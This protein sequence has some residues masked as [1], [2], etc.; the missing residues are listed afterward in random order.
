MIPLGLFAIGLLVRAAVGSAFAGP[1]YPDSYYYVNVAHQIAAGNGLTVDYIWN[2]VEVGGRLP[3]NPMLPIPANAHW[4]P[5]AALVQVPFIW[6]LGPVPL[7]SGVPLWLIG[8]LAAPLTYWIAREAGLGTRLAVAAGLLAAVPGALTPF[9]GQPDNFGLFMT[10]GAL[11]LW[12]CARGM[13]GDRRA[14]V[15][16]GLVVGAAT[17]ARS[18]AIL[19]GIPFA[20]AYLRE[21]W[22][23][24]ERVVGFAAAAGCAALFALVVGPWLYRQLEVFGSIAPSAAN[25]RILWISDYGQLYS[26]ATETTLQTLLAAGPVALLASRIGGL[27]AALGTLR[28]AAAGGR[29]GRAGTRRRVGAPARHSFWSLLRLRH[30]PLRGQRDPVRRSR[31]PRHIHPLGRGAAAAHVRA[32]RNRDQRAGRLGC[33]ASAGLGCRQGGHLP[34][35]RGS[36]GRNPWRGSPDADHGRPLAS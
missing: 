8:A 11:S 3:A 31:P 35:L 2:F 15:L 10:L 27:L 29:P 25:G 32:G 13:A 26:V 12:L 34:R 4:M 21:L 17:L 24:R 14:F 9:F 36:R 22:P 23:G 28:A 20:L 6:L 19:L 18:D 30:L 7:A 5:L 1:A 16:G 33:A